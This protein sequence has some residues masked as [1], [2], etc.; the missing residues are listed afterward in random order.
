M[1]WQAEGTKPHLNQISESQ[2]MTN[3]RFNLLKYPYCVRVHI[4]INGVDLPQFQSTRGCLPY[5]RWVFPATFR[6]R[7]S[8][9]W[10]EK[11]WGYSLKCSE[12]NGTRINAN[13][14]PI[15]RKNG[16]NM[17]TPKLSINRPPTS[18]TSLTRFTSTT[19]EKL[20]WDQ[21]DTHPEV[22]WW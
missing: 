21:L 22:E 5:P 6:P 8:K 9:S 16:P 13:D 19:E 3:I 14:V 11:N 18:T 12:S 15:N 20:W 4:F 7:E 10:L 17:A 2:H 1:R